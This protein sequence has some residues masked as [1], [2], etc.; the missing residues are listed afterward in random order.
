LDG[1]EEMMQQKNRLG[2]TISKSVL[3]ILYLKDSYFLASKSNSSIL[4]ALSEM[5]EPGPKIAAAPA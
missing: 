4:V 5:I 1:I 2:E 3:I